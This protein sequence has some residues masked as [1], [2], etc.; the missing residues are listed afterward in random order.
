MELGWGGCH[1]LDHKLEEPY[2]RRICPEDGQLNGDV[3][4]EAWPSGCGG[5]S[6]V[7][8]IANCTEKETNVL[9]I[10]ILLWYE[11]EKSKDSVETNFRCVNK[12]N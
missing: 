2:L 8:N 1:L 6:S 9:I 7:V 3:V 11:Y 5:P 4:R 10:G 12:R